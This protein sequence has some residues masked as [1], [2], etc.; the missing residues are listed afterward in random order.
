MWAGEGKKRGALSSLTERSQELMWN[1]S[2]QDPDPVLSGHE[3]IQLTQQ[4]LQVSGRFPEGTPEDGATLTLI[5]DRPERHE[6]Q[7]LVDLRQDVGPV[8]HGG[9]SVPDL[10]H[11]LP[12]TH[13][14]AD[15]HH[16]VACGGG[17]TGDGEHTHTHT[18]VQERRG[19]PEAQ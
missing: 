6:G 1:K 15:A 8:G 12:V 5:K 2:E 3:D 17:A 16:L 11:V 18:R 4:N 19:S 9:V 7:Q 10:N 13:A 14:D